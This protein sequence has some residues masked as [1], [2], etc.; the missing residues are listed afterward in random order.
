MES[1]TLRQRTMQ[2]VTLISMSIVV[3]FTPMVMIATVL[4]TARILVT[5]MMCTTAT[6][7]RCALDA[8][9]RDRLTLHRGQDDSTNLPVLG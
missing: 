9:L 3:A 1:V 5:A 2:F 4:F 6:R 8:G 7:L